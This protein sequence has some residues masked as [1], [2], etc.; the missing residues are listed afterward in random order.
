MS[1]SIQLLLGAHLHTEAS[2]IA[3]LPDALRLLTVESLVVRA[4]REGAEQAAAIV[5]KW[6]LRL[7][8]LINGQ[9]DSLGRP[10]GFALA[11]ETS[12]QSEAIFLGHGKAW[13]SSAMAALSVR[14]V[15]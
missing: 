4:E 1:R 13:T 10:A 15:L 8:S 14:C 11:L 6:V 7:S 12:R 2:T 3:C 9:R 5:H